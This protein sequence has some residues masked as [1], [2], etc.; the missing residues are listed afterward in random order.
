MSWQRQGS[1]GYVNGDYKITRFKSG[2]R[3]SAVEWIVR[4]QGERVASFP[5]LAQAKV[6]VVPHR[7]PVGWEHRTQPVDAAPAPVEES[8]LPTPPP[9]KVEVGRVR[10]P[11]GV[12]S[13]AAIGA[14]FE[15]EWPGCTVRQVGSWLLFEIDGE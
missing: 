6:S 1:F 11:I 9:P 3:G 5:T 8:I 13:V 12:R 15:K 14:G 4:Y 10:M 7:P 2:L